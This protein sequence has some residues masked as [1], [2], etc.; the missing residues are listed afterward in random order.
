V[1]YSG[2]G[3]Q[4]SYEALDEA[5]RL[6]TQGRFSLPVAR[7]FPVADAPEA[8]RISEAGHV[9]GKLVLLVD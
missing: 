5:A 9:R 7:T 8:H 4:R 2:G 1:P 6:F 3:G